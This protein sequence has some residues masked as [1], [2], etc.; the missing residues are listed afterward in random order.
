MKPKFDDLKS[1]LGTMAAEL[2]VFNHEIHRMKRELDIEA[3][4][5]RLDVVDSILT[6]AI[7]Q[8]EET[9]EVRS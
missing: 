5:R 3:D 6:V 4:S 7:R 8:A 1:D 9:S 2:R